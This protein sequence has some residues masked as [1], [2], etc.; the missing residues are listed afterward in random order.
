MP[1]E[2]GQ[3]APETGPFPL[4]TSGAAPSP[5]GGPVGTK[6]NLKRSCSNHLPSQALAGRKGQEAECHV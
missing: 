3:V 4:A 2:H 6:L 5:G 1:Y